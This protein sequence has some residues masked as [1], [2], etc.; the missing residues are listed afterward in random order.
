MHARAVALSIALVV[1][2]TLAA[3]VPAFAQGGG[4]ATTEDRKQAAKE[5]A[6]GDHAFKGGDFKGAAEAYERAY[7]ALPH[8]SALW[9]AAR[10]WFRAGDL[11]RAANLYARYLN[12][13]PTNARDRNNALKSLQSLSEK[14]A[15]LQIHATDVQDVKV[16]GDATTTTDVYVTPG[17]HVVEGHTSD[18]KPVRQSQNV[19]AG[20]TVSVA[21]MAPTTAPASGGT[22][23]PPVPA[24]QGQKKSRGL[25]PIVVVFG[26]AVT[27]VLGGITVWSGLDTLNQKDT[28]DQSPTQDNLD[29][30]RQK[31]TRTN[32][33]IG[34]TIGAGVLTGVVAIFFVDWKGSA[35]TKKDDAPT[36]AAVENVRLGVGPGSVLVQGEF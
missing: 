24:E 19:E 11:P 25:S 7:R 15:H 16:D 36:G 3:P 9:N 32:I 35:A 28:F 21:L 14:L 22:P 12:E 8:Y 6:D 4:T 30:G 29:V 23:P 18:G 10:A 31:Q 27:A 5:F 1:G 26:G 2:T 20:E 33:L 17:A 34:A 13:A